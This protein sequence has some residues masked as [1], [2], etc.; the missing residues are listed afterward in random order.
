MLFAGIDYS[1]RFSVTTIIDHKG[2]IIQKGRLLNRRSVF[3]DFFRGL[4]KKRVKAVIEAGRNYHVAGDLIEGLVEEIQLAHPLKVRAIAE[5]KIKTDSIDSETLARLLR[6]DLI[7]QAYFRN[8]GEREKQMVL[9]LR[10]FWVRQRTRLRNRIHWLIDGQEEEVRE[11]ASEFSDL[12]GC[13][14]RAWLARQQ[15]PTLADDALREL[16]DL[17]QR[18]GEKIKRSDSVGEA[19]LRGR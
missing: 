18:C 14:G 7:P 4:K 3:E 1:K 16:L 12:F 13:K 10:S 8:R 5:A 17:E 19:L 6:A 15:L 2:R 11:T 9:R